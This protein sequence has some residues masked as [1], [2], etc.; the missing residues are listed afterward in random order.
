[1]SGDIFWLI[2]LENV[3]LLVSSRW[4]PR[5]LNILWGTGQPMTKDYLA[6]NV[7]GGAKTKKQTLSNVLICI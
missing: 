2:K 6:L 7:G 3:A 1:M 5:M 4:R